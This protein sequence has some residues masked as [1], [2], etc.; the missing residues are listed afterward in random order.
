MHDLTEIVT[1]TMGNVINKEGRSS[2]EEE[3]EEEE[4]EEIE[5]YFLPSDGKYIK[6]LHGTS[7]IIL[8]QL[9]R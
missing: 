6:T 8:P 3:E 9:V 5:G 1:F 7:D 2:S 4:E